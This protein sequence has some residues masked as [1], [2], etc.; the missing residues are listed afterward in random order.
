MLKKKLRE[1]HV[2]INVD[3]ISAVIQTHTRYNM[4]QREK[5]FSILQGQMIE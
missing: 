1:M 4:D 2:Q 3:A 5:A